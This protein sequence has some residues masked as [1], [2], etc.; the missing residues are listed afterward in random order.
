MAYII[1]KATIDL[2]QHG[3]KIGFSC[4]GHDGGQLIAADLL[5]HREL[6]EVCQGTQARLL[7]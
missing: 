2:P 5:L 6:A 1:A 4:R 7:N 3:L